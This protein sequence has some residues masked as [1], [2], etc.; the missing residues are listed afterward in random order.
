MMAKGTRAIAYRTN[1]ESG[2]RPLKVPERIREL[3]DDALVL[4]ILSGSDAAFTELHWRYRGRLFVFVMEI[5][6]DREKT[7]DVIQETFFRI[8][9]HLGRFDRRMK[10]ST[11]IYTIAYRI[12]LNAI[13]T[14]RRGTWIILFRDLGE[15]RN[16]NDEEL[17]FSNTRLSTERLCEEEHL[18][19]LVERAVAELPV[20][21]R[22]IFYMR[23][24]EGRTYNEMARILGCPVGTAK[25]RLH[26]ARKAF[27]QIIEPMLA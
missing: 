1:T 14:Y 7:E 3:S 25:N 17:E 23:E 6:G 4:A 15:K 8:H 10:L 2:P 26:H 21:F 22:I 13:R 5:V 19:E 11:W 12:A 9:K 20:N 18:R 16:P 27:A 24:L